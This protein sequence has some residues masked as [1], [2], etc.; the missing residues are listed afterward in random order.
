MRTKYRILVAAE[1]LV[2]ITFLFVIFAVVQNGIF[3]AKNEFVACIEHDFDYKAVL[4]RIKGLD[5]PEA[6]LQQLSSEIEMIPYEKTAAVINTQGVI[7]V[8]S[9]QKNNNATAEKTLQNYVDAAQNSF[10]L[11]DFETP[12]WVKSTEKNTSVRFDFYCLIDKMPTV[13]FVEFTLS[14]LKAVFL[15]DNFLFLF[16]ETTVI[17]VFIQI[18]TLFFFF[19]YRKKK[20]QLE[21]SHYYFMNGIAHEIKTPITEIINLTECA[22]IIPSS[23]ETEK[24]LKMISDC[25]EKMNKIVDLFLKNSFYLGERK[26]I[27]T[28][29]SLSEVVRSKVAEFSPF[30][31]EKGV[32][33]NTEYMDSVTITADRQLIDIV[34]DNFLSNALKYTNTGCSITIKTYNKRKKVG[35]SIHNQTDLSVD[36]KSIWDSAFEPDNGTGRI[37]GV[38]LSLSKKILQLHKFRYGCRM[39]EGGVLFFFET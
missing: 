25:S 10:L 2:F 27:K 1:I 4:Q 13:L 38:G 34:I 33:V 12:H 6:F 19:E 9:S 31:N 14:P 22:A 32:V 17:F 21:K 24:Y 3:A 8:L 5:D 39:E 37:H 35:F 28:K 11:S 23:K 7:A 20:D 16:V 26:L 36:C 30:F 15:N 18:A 29:I